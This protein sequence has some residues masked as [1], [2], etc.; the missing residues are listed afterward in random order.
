MLQLRNLTLFARYEYLDLNSR[1]PS[2]AFTM[3]ILRKNYTIVGIT[4]QAGAR[5]NGE[6]GL[7]SAHDG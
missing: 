5:R 3:G 6:G 7:C 4:W 1:L 2:T